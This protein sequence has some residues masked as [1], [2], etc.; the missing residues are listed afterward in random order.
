[1]E[2]EGWEKCGSAVLLCCSAAV[3]QSE[4]GKSKRVETEREMSNVKVQN[5]NGIVE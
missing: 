3:L 2:A 1:M 4:R 5:L